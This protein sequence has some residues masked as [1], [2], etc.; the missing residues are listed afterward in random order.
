MLNVL[1]LP[2]IYF[3]ISY[4]PNFSCDFVYDLVYGNVLFY[5]HFIYFVYFVFLLVII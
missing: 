4:K 3:D 2:N 1:V 5:V